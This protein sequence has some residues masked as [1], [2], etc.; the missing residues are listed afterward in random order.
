MIVNRYRYIE[1]LSRSKNNGLIKIITGLRRSGKSFL[2]KKLFHQHLLDEGVREDHILVIDMESRKNREFKNPDYLLDWVEKMMIDYETYYIIIDEVQEVEDFVEVLSSLSVTE[3]ADVYVTGSNSRFLSSDLVTEFRG[4]GDEIHV[5][6]LSF[7]EFMTVYDGSKEDGWAEYRLYGGLPQLLTQVGDE[8]KADFLRRLYRT[9]Y[10]RD[11]YERNNIELRP[12]FEEL[13]KT[14]ASSIGAPVN[15]L[16]IANTFKSVSNVQSITDKTVS[17]YLEYM[18][19]AFLI[20]KS[21]RFDIKGRKYIGSLSKYYYQDVGLRNAILSFRQSEPTHIMENVIY[22][23]MRMRGWLVDVGNVYHRVRNTEGKQQRVTLEVDF[24][25]NKGS[26][27][28]Y[29]QS[30]WRMPDAEKMEQE[31]R[32]LRLVDD[33]FRKLLIVGE[34]SKQWSDENGIQI[35]S[36]YDFLL[37]WSS[38]E[39]HG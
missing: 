34:H 18:Q 24:V 33:S 14:V 35:M 10:L 20:E 15:A 3:G 4:R 22:N 12:E 21:E 5:W 38:T 32:S 16:N 1:Q 36:I 17:A 26:E 37:D 2:L 39:K 29:I 31:K 6:P 11:I 9:V 7:K 23:E 8:K 19:D 28:I 13:S 30:A 27:R 25:C